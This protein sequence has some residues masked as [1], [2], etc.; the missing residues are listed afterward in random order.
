MLAQCNYSIKGFNG[1]KAA[2]KSFADNQLK[3]AQAKA[4]SLAKSAAAKRVAAPRKLNPN[5]YALFQCAFDEFPLCLDCSGDDASARPGSWDAPVVLRSC[6]TIRA[7][8]N[9]APLKLNALVFRSGMANSP[10]TNE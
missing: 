9:A 10:Q 4:K 5:Q 2:E 6:S 7:A 1:A 3:K 8:S